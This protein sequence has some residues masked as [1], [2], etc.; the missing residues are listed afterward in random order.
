MWKT[1]AET[2]RNS[3][4]FKELQVHGEDAG[5]RWNGSTSTHLRRRTGNEADRFSGDGFRQKRTRN[6]RDADGFVFV[7]L[8]TR[9]ARQ[10]W[11]EMP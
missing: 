10:G 9:E 5:T 3:L 4:N 8:M 11:R 7:D 1:Q 6:R 2:G